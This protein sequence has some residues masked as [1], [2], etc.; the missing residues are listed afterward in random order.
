[1]GINIIIT[2]R[3]AVRDIGGCSRATVYFG[4]AKV[5]N[6]ELV[7]EFAN[8]YQKIIRLNISVDI[9]LCV[10]ILDPRDELIRKKQDRF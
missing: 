2:S 3:S 1:M 6:I 7:F 8:S 4:R 5:N 9:R 10:D